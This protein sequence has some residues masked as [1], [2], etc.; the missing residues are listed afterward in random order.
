VQHTIEQCSLQPGQGIAFFYFDFTDPRKQDRDMLLRSLLQQFLGQVKER[1]SDQLQRYIHPK[2]QTPTD[3]L[4]L[5]K[6]AIEDFDEAFILIDALDE[7]KRGPDREK[8]IGLL[9]ELRDW[10][11]SNLH[12]LV[13]SRGEKDIRDGLNPRPSEEV[14]IEHQDAD[15]KSY[16][17]EQLNTKKAL[18]KWRPHHHEIRNALT[19]GAH[20]M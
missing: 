5:L 18:Q 13:T 7:C 14:S 6:E 10:K 4:S 19:S 17:E 20:G 16:V 8:V 3:L 9:T 12:I 15:I 2:T 1:L 11:V